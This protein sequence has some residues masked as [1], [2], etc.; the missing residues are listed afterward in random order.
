MLPHGKMRGKLF[1]DHV[2]QQYKEPE[3]HVVTLHPEQKEIFSHPLHI[4]VNGIHKHEG[5][6]T[7]KNLFFF[8]VKNNH[9]FFYIQEFWC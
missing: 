7:P 6:F 3:S 8:Y 5:S 9:F 2:R 4:N 1:Y